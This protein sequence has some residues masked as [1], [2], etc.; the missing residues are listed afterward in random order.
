MARPLVTF[1]TDF[2]HHDPF[3]G[4]MKG[5]ILGL[6]PEAQIVDLCHG[7]RPQD[8]TAAAFWIARC[9]RYFPAGTVHVC[10]VDPGVGSN[11][12]ALLVS[13]DSQHFIAPDNGILSELIAAPG[14]T[15]L[16]ELIPDAAPLKS[17]FHGRDLF[18][19]AAAEWLLAMM[20]RDGI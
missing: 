8:I 16:H 6:C 3:V 9:Y 7:I 5:V 19:P 13:H 12:R 17:T 15:V 11:R 10:V 1:L 20:N 18:A 4:V 2:G 14:P